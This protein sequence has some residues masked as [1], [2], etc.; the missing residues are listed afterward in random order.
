MLNIVPVL[1]QN[2]LAKQAIPQILPGDSIPGQTSLAKSN[3]TLAALLS[4][5]AAMF[6][7]KLNSL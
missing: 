7:V 3:H 1:W 2:E 5:A 4:N 6:W